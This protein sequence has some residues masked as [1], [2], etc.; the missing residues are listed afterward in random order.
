[1]EKC[2]LCTCDLC[3]QAV[4]KWVRVVGR[5]WKEGRDWPVR[6]PPAHCC[7]PACHAQSVTS[8]LLVGAAVTGSFRAAPGGWSGGARLLPVPVMTSPVSWDYSILWFLPSGIRYSTDVSVDEVKALASLMT[9]KCAVVG[10]SP[11]PADSLEAPGRLQLSWRL[12]GAGSW[13][14]QF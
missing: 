8:D 7:L 3:T 4:S 1:M 11:R 12:R 9:Y 2:G 5:V 6:S 10:E 13:Y 14:V